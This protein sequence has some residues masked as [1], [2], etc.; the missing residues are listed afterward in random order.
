MSKSKMKLVNIISYLDNLQPVLEKFVTFPCFEPVS[1]DKIIDTV[2]GTSAYTS[3]DETTPLLKEISDIEHDYKIEIDTLSIESAIDSFDSMK[4]EITFVHKKLQD[5]VSEKKL[6]FDLLKKYE[7]AYTQVDYISTLDVSLDDIFSCS[8]IVA[9]VGTLPLDSV[10]KLKY[11]TTKPFIFKSF[12]EDQKVSWCMYFTTNFLEREVDNIFS[13]LLFERIYIP[14]FVHGTPEDA[15][16]Y[17]KSEIE[18]TKGQIERVDIDTLELIHIHQEPLIQMKSELLLLDKVQKAEKY[19]V[20][21][22]A[23]FYITG[24]IDENHEENVNQ[25]FSSIKD[26]EVIFR[27][28]DSDKRLKV[29]KKINKKI[30][31]K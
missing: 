8:Y 3:L 16:K 21:L 23:R 17:L 1:S 9:R 27:P 11:Y 10:D 30:C 2:H 12:K 31:N 26:V 20:V 28:S 14:D 25:L 6:L 19:V 18:V 24:F 13:S 15:M 4:D 22:G 7:D 29:P 5:L